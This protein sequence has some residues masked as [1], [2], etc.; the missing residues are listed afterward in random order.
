MKRKYSWESSEWSLSIYALLICIGVIV[1]SMIVNPD[2]ILIY[3][4][5][6]LSGSLLIVVI[7]IFYVIYTKRKSKLKK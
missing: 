2:F 4:L 3:I 5:G 1:G 6:A 7:N